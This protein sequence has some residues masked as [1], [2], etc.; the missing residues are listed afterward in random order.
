MLIGLNGRA[1]QTL[2]IASIA[3]NQRRGNPVI[4]REGRWDLQ[5]SR[6]QQGPSGSKPRPLSVGDMVELQGSVEVLI[7]GS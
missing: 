6:G 2:H 3:S 1:H 4:L 5:R 7:H